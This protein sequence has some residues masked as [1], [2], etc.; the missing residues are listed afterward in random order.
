LQ[1]IQKGFLTNYEKNRAANKE[2]VYYEHRLFYLELPI[3]YVIEGKKNSFI[4][5]LIVSYLYDDIWRFSHVQTF[6]N[7]SGGVTTI[8]NVNDAKQFPFFDRYNIFDF[9][10]NL[11]FSRK[12]N[13]SLSFEFTIQ[14]HFL[15]VD[16]WK[17]ED[18]RYNLCFLTGLR[19]NPF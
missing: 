1:L 4:S 10:L 15:N 14:K 5:G 3:N 9:G 17:T 11:G 6:Y 12:I 8:F 19:Y 2:V 7:N 18:L 16:N 13:E